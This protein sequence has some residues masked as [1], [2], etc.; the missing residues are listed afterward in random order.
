MYGQGNTGNA[1]APQKAPV[2]EVGNEL[3]SLSQISL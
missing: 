1:A 3:T 2:P